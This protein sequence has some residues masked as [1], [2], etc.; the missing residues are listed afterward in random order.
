MGYSREKFEIYDSINLEL[1]SRNPEIIED[2]INNLFQLAYNIFAVAC[3]RSLF[4]YLF[5]SVF[6][7]TN[8][9]EKYLISLIQTINLKLKMVKFH[10]SLI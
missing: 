8:N 2:D 9:K 4:I 3:R 5:Y 1:L 6:D 7:Y 10:F